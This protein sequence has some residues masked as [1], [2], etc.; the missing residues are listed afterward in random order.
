[1]IAAIGLCT[2]LGSHSNLG[3][4]L[5]RAG[6]F[7][8][9]NHDSVKFGRLVYSKLMEQGHKRDEIISCSVQIIE[10]ICLQLFPRESEVKEAVDF[11]KHGAQ[12]I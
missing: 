2:D 6:L 4:N 7:E 12:Q 3:S 9:M 5:G 10:H 8:M 11:T 1:M